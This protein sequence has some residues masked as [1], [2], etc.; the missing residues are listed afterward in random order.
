LLS[1]HTDIRA[2]EK[3]IITLKSSELS[4]ARGGPHCLTFP[5]DRI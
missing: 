2:L 3:T 1:K 4:R 5:L